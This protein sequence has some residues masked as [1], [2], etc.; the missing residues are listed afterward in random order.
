[1]P[2]AEEVFR[3][4]TIGDARLIRE[5]ESARTASLGLRRLDERAESLL[6]IGALVALD[7]PE[8]SYRAAIGAATRAGADLEDLLAVLIAVAEPV[9]SVR[10][11]A[12]APRIALAAGYDVDAALERSDPISDDAADRG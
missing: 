6:R 9:G 10:I 8:A 1:M 11:A 2:S 7:A 3:R 12:A 4:L 5:F